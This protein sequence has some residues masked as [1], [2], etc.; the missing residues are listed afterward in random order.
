MYAAQM[1]VFLFA[2]RYS[3]VGT[4]AFTRLMQIEIFEARRDN[5]SKA[6]QASLEDELPA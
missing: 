5:Q 4:Y 6:H 1:F 2:P 3:D